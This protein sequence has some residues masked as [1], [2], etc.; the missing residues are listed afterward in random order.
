MVLVVEDE[1]T[2]RCLLREGLTDEGYGVYTAENAHEALRALEEDQA[3]IVL[4]DLMLPGMGGLELASQ[5]RKR[6][7]IWIVAM[8]ASPALLDRA[9]HHPCVDGSVSKPFDWDILIKELEKMS[10]N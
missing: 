1:P 9:D 5:I 4:L 7:P 10:P 8:S 3:D 6:W 2:L